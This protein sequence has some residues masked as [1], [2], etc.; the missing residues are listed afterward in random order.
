MDDLDAERAR[1]AKQ[2]RLKAEEDFKFVAK[3]ERGQRVLRRILEQAGIFQLSFAGESTHTT[4]FNEGRRNIGLFVNAE[5]LSICPEQWAN[6][7]KAT[8]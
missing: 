5:I 4:A 3:D 6:I 2:D 8:E 1:K 7:M